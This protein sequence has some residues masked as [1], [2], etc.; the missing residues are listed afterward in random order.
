MENSELEDLVSKKAKDI[1]DQALAAQKKEKEP[2]KFSVDEF[3]KHQENCNDPDCP[4]C[5]PIRKQEI[6]GKIKNLKSQVSKIEQ[7]R[8]TPEVKKE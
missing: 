8:K 4:A 2:D 7:E 6:T 1:V 3:V 5:M